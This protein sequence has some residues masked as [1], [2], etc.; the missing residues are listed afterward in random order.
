MEKYKEI[1]ELAVKDS[2]TMAEAAR[3]AELDYRIF[4]QYAIKYDLFKPNAAGKG[5]IK[6]NVYEHLIEKSKLSRYTLKKSLIRLKLLTNK[7]Y[8]CNINEWMGDL[9]TLQ[10]DHI[11]GVR[12]DNRI[13][14][15]R[16]LCPNCHSQTDTFTGK[17][18]KNSIV[19]DEQ[20]RESFDKSNNFFQM[21]MDLNLHTGE[22]R[23]IKN[24]MKNLGLDFGC[25][26]HY[27]IEKVSEK[28]LKVKKTRNKKTFSCKCG[29]NIT[30]YAKNCLDCSFIKKRKTERPNQEA[31]EELMKNHSFCFIGR[32][33][34]VSDNA[35]RKWAR[36]YKLL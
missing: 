24:R 10:I 1:I 26:I 11:N 19:S 9:I 7:C 4:R 21:C 31:L 14:N 34:N 6:I 17:N 15:L 23:S 32:K 13:E 35:V 33:Y 18:K 5:V 2:K 20:I 30:K 25:K 16:L 8:I 12:N 22:N 27:N 3:K 29:K 28:K 36:S